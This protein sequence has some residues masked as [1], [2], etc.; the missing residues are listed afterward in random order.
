MEYV[1]G[2]DAIYQGSSDGE[3]ESTSATPA[4]SYTPVAY[5]TGDSAA[6]SSV[7]TAVFPSEV[8][9]E[10]FLGIHWAVDG[11]D[12]DVADGGAEAGDPRGGGAAAHGH[13]AL[14]A[15]RHRP[16]HGRAAMNGIDAPRPLN[17]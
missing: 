9:S 1:S 11:T 4:T 3:V 6:A 2:G 5:T 8:T 13:G 14:P 12:I 7:I 15:D 17:V 16:A 10:N